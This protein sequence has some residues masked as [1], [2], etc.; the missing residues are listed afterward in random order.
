MVAGPAE[1]SLTRSFGLPTMS[2][3]EFP[4]ESGF[5]RNLDQ[6]FGGVLSSMEVDIL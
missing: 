1:R 5:M 4:M 2:V 3:N 6:P